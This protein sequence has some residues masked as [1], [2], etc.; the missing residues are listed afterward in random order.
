MAMVPASSQHTWVISVGPEDT[1][2]FRQVWWWD[3]AASSGTFFFQKSKQ[4]CLSFI[5]LPHGLRD[6]VL[7]G[8]FLLQHECWSP[9]RCGIA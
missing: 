7:Y 2:S 8:F 3:G 1:R 6:R 4:K 9:R 5:L